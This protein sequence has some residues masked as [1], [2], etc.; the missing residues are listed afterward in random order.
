MYLAGNVA[1]YIGIGTFIVSFIAII[2]VFI[3]GVVWLC[4]RVIRRSDRRFQ[5]KMAR[6]ANS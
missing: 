2:V 1:A 3:V 4:H 5:R 6:R